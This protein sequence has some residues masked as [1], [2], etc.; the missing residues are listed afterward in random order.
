MVPEVALTRKVRTPKAVVKSGLAETL[1][2]VVAG[3][4]LIVNI[5]VAGIQEPP[6]NSSNSYVSP[7]VQSAD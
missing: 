2:V 5:E 6:T 3:G 4:Y 1:N 7:P